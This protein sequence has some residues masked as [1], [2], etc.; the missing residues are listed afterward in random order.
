[1]ATKLFQVALDVTDQ[2]DVQEN[3]AQQLQQRYDKHED[4]EDHGTERDLFQQHVGSWDD[5]V[6]VKDAVLLEVERMTSKGLVQNRGIDDLTRRI[7]K[8][9]SFPS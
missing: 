3:S 2:R 6:P 9:Q 5:I 7:G 8:N 1:M 4:C